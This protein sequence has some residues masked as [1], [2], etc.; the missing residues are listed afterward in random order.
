MDT[1]KACFLKFLNPNRSKSYHCSCDS[2]CQ[3]YDQET[4]KCLLINALQVKVVLPLE[5]Y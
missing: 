3:A 1:D 5:D 4:C 2:D